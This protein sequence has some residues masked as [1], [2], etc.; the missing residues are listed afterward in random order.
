MTQQCARYYQ[1]ELQVHRSY[2]KT[3]LTHNDDISTLEARQDRSIDIV[4]KLMQIVFKLPKVTHILEFH[5]WF[6]ILRYFW[7]YYLARL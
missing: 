4:M 5:E 7:Q 6:W 3:F 1:I 2:S